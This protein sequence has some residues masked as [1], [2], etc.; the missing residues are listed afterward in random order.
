VKRIGTSEIIGDPVLLKPKRVADP[1]SVL[2][3]AE[4]KK[5]RRGM[6]QIREGNFKLWR[7]IKNEVGR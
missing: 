1:A 2:T 7:D 6:K 3:P 5:V 4:A